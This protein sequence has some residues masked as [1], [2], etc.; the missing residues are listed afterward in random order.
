MSPNGEPMGTYKYWSPRAQQTMVDHVKGLLQLYGAGM[1][2]H[3]KGSQGV[4]MQTMFDPIV[5]PSFDAD[6]RQRYL[7][8]LQKRYAGN[9]ARLNSLYGLEAGSFGELKPS[10][11][12]L[13]PEELNWVSCA[14]PTADDFDRRT[15]N[16]YRWI[17]N[18]TYLSE[19]TESYFA[20]MKAR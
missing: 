18:Q 16:F 14:R 20:A 6:G 19:E 13:R 12:W 5:K 8:W 17:D 3:A 1:R 4:I 10:E 2:R 15:A 7:T 11:Y 9:I